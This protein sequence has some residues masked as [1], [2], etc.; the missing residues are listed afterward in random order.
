MGSG[1]NQRATVVALALAALV[2][3]AGVGMWSRAPAVPSMTPDPVTTTRTPTV[4]VHVAGWVMSPGVVTVPES[5][6]VA[7]AIEAAGGLRPGALVDRINLAAVVVPGEQIVVP[8]PEEVG[9]PD[10]TSDGGLL[11]LNRATATELET[12]PGVGPV[13]ANRIVAHRGSNGRFET[14]EELLEV[15]GIGE[16]K[17]ASIRDL[18]TP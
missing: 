9:G 8:G 7:E 15:P 16:A 3:G 1:L 12:L 2:A 13:L 10:P 18:V 4:G 14:V 17:L 11:S 5:S 6:M